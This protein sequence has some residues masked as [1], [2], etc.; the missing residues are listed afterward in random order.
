MSNL[1]IYRRRQADP[2]ARIPNVLLCDPSLTWKAKGI[3]CY[4]LSKPDYWQARERDIEQRGADGATAV[5]SGL[6]EIRQAGYAQLV[7]VVNKGQVVEWRLLVSDSKEFDPKEDGRDLELNQNA[8]RPQADEPAKDLPEVDFN[9]LS[10]TDRSKNEPSNTKEAV[11]APKEA[12]SNT[13]PTQHTLVEQ[14]FNPEADSPSP[15]PACA[16][17]PSLPP[18][19]I[20]WN[21]NCGTL[22]KV[23]VMSKDRWTNLNKRRLDDRFKA[24]YQVAVR[25]VAESDFCHGKSNSGW[26]ARF[27]W[28]LQE[29]VIGKI[30]EGTYD[31]RGGPVRPAPTGEK[32]ILL[33]ALR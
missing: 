4:L 28:M 16:R 20:F 10:N 23:L 7:R 26:I 22:P 2:F 19:A 27:D 11:E 13:P 5:S 24:Q 14:S 12:A 3:L 30:M 8:S 25:R 18:E 9:P 17:P 21:E 15:N 31:N 32:D 6:K 33:A 1:N 29:D